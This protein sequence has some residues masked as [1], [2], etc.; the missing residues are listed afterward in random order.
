MWSEG[1]P[2]MIDA[3]SNI[4]GVEVVKPFD[5]KDNHFDWVTNDNIGP[6]LAR[7]I[8]CLA[9]T[10]RKEG[11]P[12]KVI[13]VAHSMG[14]LAARFAANQTID[15]RKVADE[16]G[17][18]VTLG[19]P[20]TG[21][22][23][24]TAFG[25]LPR[26]YCR[27]LVDNSLAPEQRMEQVSLCWAS[28][29]LSAMREGSNELAQLPHFPDSVPVRAIA[30]QVTLYAQYLFSDVKQPL[31][32]D[33]IVPVNS[34]LAE[35][36]NKG[37]GDGRFVFSCDLRRYDTYGSSGPIPNVKGGQCSHNE[38]YK[39]GYIQQSVT[40][41]IGDYLA[42][43][44]PNL[45]PMPDYGHFG[46]GRTTILDRLVIPTPKGWQLSFTKPGTFVNFSDDTNC[47]EQTSACP[48]IHFISI[49][50]GN[51]G[52]DLIKLWTNGHGDCVSGSPRNV[53]G[54]VNVTVGGELAQLYRQYCGN[55][56]RYAWTIP[57]KQLHIDID[58]GGDARILAGALEKAT[59][60]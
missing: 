21:S 39:T 23:W 1:K 27:L 28:S 22:P 19:T 36:T 20:N 44:S 48:H 52:D 10:S 4:D 7:T 45:A 55:A 12:G 57:S 9:Q 50:P 54:P 37:V 34:A 60:K 6:K 16:L 40:N 5:Y 35:Y 33:L 14:G 43:R 30:G 29:A 51:T 18:V 59:W 32:D 49:S 47:D 3:A 42:S 2:S 8:D 46:S 56:P 31:S 58:E 25:D 38:M 13:V 53:E 11:G 24:A 26:A 15:G 17:L 41:G